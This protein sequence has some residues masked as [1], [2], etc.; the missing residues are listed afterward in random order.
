MSSYPERIYYEINN[1][2][3]RALKTSYLFSQ[4]IHYL[5]IRGTKVWKTN[6]FLFLKNGTVRTSDLI[7]FEFS[8]KLL[9]S[10]TNAYPGEER[11]EPFHESCF[12]S[13][14]NLEKGKGL[15]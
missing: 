11:A 9:V 3:F 6:F 14:E 15:L 10:D 2:N 5:V 1:F 4:F 12:Y 7:F 13:S 8:S